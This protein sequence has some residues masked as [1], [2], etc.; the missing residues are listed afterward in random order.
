M[1]DEIDRLQMIAQELLKA[2]QTVGMVV[3]VAAKFDPAFRE[4]D[5][6]ARAAIKMARDEGL[7]AAE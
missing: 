7:R 1:N 2:L 6:I 5:G 3:A 4:V